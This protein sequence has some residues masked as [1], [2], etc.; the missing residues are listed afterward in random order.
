[1][2]CNLIRI[3]KVYSCN[4][5]SG[6]GGLHIRISSLFVSFHTIFGVFSLIFESYSKI[7]FVIF[8]SF[9]FPLR[10]NLEFKP[11]DY[12]SLLLFPAKAVH[13]NLLFLSCLEYTAE[14]R[15]SE[16]ARACVNIS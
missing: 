4:T 15:G 10:G 3:V 7:H 13:G 12:F 16:K 14:A 6:K 9:R 1:M 11:L 8:F 5:N 2:I